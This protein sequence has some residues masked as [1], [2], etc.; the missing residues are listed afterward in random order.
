M[1]PLANL[2]LSPLLATIPSLHHGFTGLLT[3]KDEVALLDQQTATAKQVHKAE[4]IWV[5]AWEKRARDA[6]A[7]ATFVPGLAIGV[8]SADCTPILVAALDEATKKVYAAMAVHGGWR[9]T[10]L[11]IA[12]KTFAQFSRD[13]KAR[14][15]GKPLCFMAAIGPCISAA[16][17]EVGEEVI[18]AFPGS[19]ERG[20]ARFLRME[21]GKRKYTFNLP[22]EN[23]RQLQA[24]AKASGDKLTVDSLDL[25][26]LSLKDRFPSIR[27]D[28]EK[29]GRILSF[30]A[31]DG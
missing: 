29:A 5:D 27:R 19:E 28:R 26:T 17:F 12:E 24:A 8:Y 18:Q 30:L 21:E 3:P 23:L 31:F 2:T 16:S 15:Q 14:A 20:L 9:G 6:D 11:G 4:L 25:C 22:G 10:A 7:V 1:R 13:A